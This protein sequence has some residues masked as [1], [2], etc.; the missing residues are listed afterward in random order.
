MVPS[1]LTSHI[2]WAVTANSV[3]PTIA[4]DVA[5]IVLVPTPAPVAKPPAVMVAVGVVPDDHVTEVV[6]FCVLVSL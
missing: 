5:L 6:K 2:D 1:W 3:E 4:P